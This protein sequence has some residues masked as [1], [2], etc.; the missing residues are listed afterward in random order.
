MQHEKVIYENDRGQRIEIAYS[1]PYFYVDLEGK[2]GLDSR[3]SKTKSPFQDG[4]SIEGESLEDR[5]LR[6]LGSIKGSSKDEIVKYRTKLL[7]AFNPKIKGTLQYEYGDTVKRIRVEV[8]KA[9]KFS[10]KNRSFK[11]HDFLIDL[12]APNPFWQDIN[13]T[14]AEI[15][16]WRGA[17]EF[18]LEIVEEGIEMGFRE[19]GLIVNVFNPGDV[20]CGMKIQFKA[21]ATVIKPSLIKPPLFNVNTREE[22]KINKTMEAGEV[23]TVTTHFQNKR[24]ELNKNGVAT[25]AFNWIE[26]TSTFLQLDVGDNLF[27]YDAETG[28]DN[29][30]VNIWFSPQY[31]GV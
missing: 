24:V 28:I 19:P 18:P 21:L 11:Y 8:E 31:L 5:P 3:I 15:A 25:N 6:L 13:T 12:I 27:R 26:P 20:E 30:E 23:I 17:F 14:K 29:L 10:K 9:P 1:F 7:R 4:Y 22:L 16:I 2:D